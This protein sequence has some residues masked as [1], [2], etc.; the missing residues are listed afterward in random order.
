MKLESNWKYRTLEDLEKETWGDAD[1]N[2]TGLVK[3]IMALRKVP[4][5]KFS[6]ARRNSTRL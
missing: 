1:A 2:G 6:V 5:N 3:H 4:L